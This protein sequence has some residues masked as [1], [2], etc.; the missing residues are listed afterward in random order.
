MT[1]KTGAKNKP[2]SVG[3]VQYR[4]KEINNVI[5][6]NSKFKIIFVLIFFLNVKNN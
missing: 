3:T 5:V 6:R 4:M 2:I 1:R